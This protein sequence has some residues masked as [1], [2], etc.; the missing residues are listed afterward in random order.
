M[1]PVSAVIDAYIT[2]PYDAM[3]RKEWD[4]VERACSYVD[5][6]GIPYLCVRPK[7]NLGAVRLPRGAWSHIPDHVRYRDRRVCPPAP[8]LKLKDT[9]V[10]DA[11]LSDGREFHGQQ[12]AVESMLFQEQGLVVRP[13]GTGKTQIAVSFIAR[14]KTNVLVL[15][16][17]ED[18]LDQWM[19]YLIN[20]GIPETEIGL[21][22]SGQVKL[23]QVTLGMVQ[24]FYKMM[25][26]EPEAWADKFGAVIVDEAHHA[27]AATWEVILNNLKAR[28]RL[29]LT[30]SPTR[31]D[32]HHPYIRLLIGPVIHIQ[33]F[34]SP[35]DV[36]VVTVPTD[37]KYRY[38]GSWDWG[39]L[40]SALVTDEK[41]NQQI[42][43]IADEE[44]R[45]GNSTLVLSRRIEHLELIAEA[46]SEPCEILTGKRTSKD[47]KRILADFRAGKS[48]VLLATQLAD[49]ALDVPILSRVILTHPGKAEGRIIQ[50]IGRA[51]REHPLKSDAIIYDVHDRKVGVLRRQF[52]NRRKLYNKLKIK[53]KGGKL[54]WR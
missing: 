26:V 6:K 34:E 19:S 22:K 44:S 12:D 33:K 8:E 2:V 54:K 17:T 52:T 36:K 4:R 10:L 27:P 3:T 11:K 18:V 42:A 29:G 40:L 7:P 21:I 24:T 28:Y 37:F 43:R 41:R 50:Q 48:R 49:E 38:R 13:P 20:A 32:G 53:V 31:A 39:N 14:C 9:F 51:I 1:S 25:L 35:V 15:V 47:R 16:H 23:G 46:M 5:A 45:S 30:A